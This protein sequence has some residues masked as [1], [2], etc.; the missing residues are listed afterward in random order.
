MAS[1]L[2]NPTLERYFTLLGFRGRGH[3]VS[4]VAGKLLTA[5]DTRGCLAPPIRLSPIAHEFLVHPTP[6]FDDS[7]PEGRIGFDRAQGCFRIRLN[8]LAG[9]RDNPAAISG[10]RRRLRFTY[11]HE[12]AHRFFFVESGDTWARAALL[13]TN[14]NTQISSEVALQEEQLCNRI[15]A[16]VLVPEC[17]LADLVT[18]CGWPEAIDQEQNLL[19]LASRVANRLD[20]TLECVLVRIERAISRQILPWHEDHIA[21]LVRLSDEA[22]EGRGAFGPRVHVGLLPSWMSSAPYSAYYPK[23]RATRWGDNF[24]HQVQARLRRGPSGASGTLQMS[25]RIPLTK[26]RRSAT[27]R[28]VEVPFH[29][30]WVLSRSGDAA[31][32]S[33]RSL[34]IWGSVGR[35]A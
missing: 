24:A 11:A 25:L 27:G 21:V 3:A 7:V 1:L 34:F 10:P 4:V 14:A 12:F 18:K 9:S 2:T 35:P 22:V 31:D 15:A 13:A 17:L 30:T 26:S 29:G 23:M 6:T 33:T 28:F 5:L 16:D 8:P 32:L 20:V 19:A